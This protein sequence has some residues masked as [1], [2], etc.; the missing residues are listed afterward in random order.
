MPTDDKLK[1]ALAKMLPEVKIKYIPNA[2][3]Y[4]YS[5][6]WNPTGQYGRGLH[7]TE[8]LHV[9]WLVEQT[10][11]QNETFDYRQEL[12]DAFSFSIHSVT[13]AVSASWQQR[14]QALAKVKGV[15]V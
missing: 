3:I 9:C 10:L 6:M 4:E 13:P 8:L 12:Q 7:D 2:E 11:N 1:L 15:E 14:A 5:F